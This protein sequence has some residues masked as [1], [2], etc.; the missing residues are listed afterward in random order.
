MVDFWD[1]RNLPAA[2]RKL[3]A[4]WLK[5]FHV[6]HRPETVQ[7]FE[8]LHGKSVVNLS[9]EPLYGRYAYLAGLERR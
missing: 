5:I 2:F 9:I 6:E 4:G 3:L 1:Q 7:Y 8:E